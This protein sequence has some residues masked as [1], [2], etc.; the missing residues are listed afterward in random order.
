MDLNQQLSEHFQ[1]WEFVVSQTAERNGI[2]NIPPKEAIIGL[3]NLCKTILEPARFALGPLQISSG[4]RS[5]E[6]NRLVGGSPT[7]AHKFGFAADII[8]LKVSKIEFAKW[9]FKNVDFDQIIL[10]F[11][12][13]DDPAW[14]HV[15]ADPRYRRQVL[16]ILHGETY[17]AVTL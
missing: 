2:K 7:S 6:L 3:K 8:P 12:K 11:G 16:Q 13:E 10:E 5:Q 9:V 17:K 1:L 4:Y 15:S 14:I